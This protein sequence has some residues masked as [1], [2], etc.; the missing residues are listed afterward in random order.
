MVS[1]KE[2]IWDLSALFESATDPKI[3]IT[4]KNVLNSVLILKKEYT[5][6]INQKG[7]SPLALKALLERIDEVYLAFSE[8]FT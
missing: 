6:R 7:F 3:E 1:Q 8:V 4:I 5:G 2:L